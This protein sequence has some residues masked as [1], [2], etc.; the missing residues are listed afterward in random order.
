MNAYDL[1]GV[2][3]SDIE[4]DGDIHEFLYRRRKAHP[5]FIPPK[6]FCIITARPLV[7]EEITKEW[8]KE[9]NIEPEY[10]KFNSYT[11]NKDDI[12]DLFTIE[13]AINHKS[14]CIDED[15]NIRIFI[16]SDEE[17]A[18]GIR[19]SIKRNDVIVYHFK[20]WLLSKIMED[21]KIW[22]EK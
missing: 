18:N 5:I 19:N 20:E 2:L 13:D 8:L 11:T 16:E 9:H 17:Q 4:I 10:V 21:N 3:L 7:D 1:D 15:S 14:K 12:F 6:P 22:Q